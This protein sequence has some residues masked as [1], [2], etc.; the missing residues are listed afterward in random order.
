[1]RRRCR[2]AVCLV[3]VAVAASLTVVAFVPATL[4]AGAFA[5]AVLAVAGF[6]AAALAVA[7]F[8]AARWWRSRAIRFWSRVLSAT[9]PLA[10]DFVVVLD[11]RAKVALERTRAKTQT[12]GSR[13][14]N[15]I[16]I[17]T[18][19]YPE[20]FLPGNFRSARKN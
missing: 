19:W 9:C 7:R 4:A 11:V 18:T 10:L 16:A 15:V 14:R 5:A 3:A 6:A 17:T 2:L 12:K 13:S 8:L 20:K 1:M